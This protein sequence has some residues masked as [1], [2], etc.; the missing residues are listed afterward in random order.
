MTNRGVSNTSGS[1]QTFSFH[2]P[3][4]DVCAAIHVQSGQQGI[5]RRRENPV[6]TEGRNF[7][8]YGDVTAD[9]FVL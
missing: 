4:A 7:S 5:A 1:E 2:G 6:V 8:A 9:R 3:H